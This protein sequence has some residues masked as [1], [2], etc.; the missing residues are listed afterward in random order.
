MTAPR[1]RL[2]RA[3]S[4]LAALTRTSFAAAVAYRSQ[5]LV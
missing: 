1:P 2:A 4:L 5:F 3:G